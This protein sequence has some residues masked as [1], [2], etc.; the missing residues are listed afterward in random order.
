MG[1]NNSIHHSNQ[2]HS[3]IILPVANNL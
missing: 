2:M 3:T 1:Q